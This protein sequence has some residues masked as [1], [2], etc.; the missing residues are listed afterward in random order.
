MAKE[1]VISDASTM[2]GL[3]S[4]EAFDLLCQLFGEVV[5]TTVV[6]DEVLAG[7]DRPDVRELTGAVA[8]GWIKVIHVRPIAALSASLDVGEATTLTP[9][10]EHSGLSLVLMDEAIGR[11]C[12][13]PDA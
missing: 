4:A 13:R 8:D 6:R 11:S 1:L 5:V 9:A 7:G 3:A 10:S 12:A 2:I